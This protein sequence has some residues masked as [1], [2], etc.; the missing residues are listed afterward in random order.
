MTSL[1]KAGQTLPGIVPAWLRTLE[2]T[3]SSEKCSGNKATWRGE[4]YLHGEIQHFIAADDVV[5]RGLKNLVSNT[6]VLIGSQKL[7]VSS[8]VTRVAQLT[9]NQGALTLTGLTLMNPGVPLTV[10]ECLFGGAALTEEMIKHVEQLVALIASLKTPMREFLIDLFSNSEIT[11]SFVSCPASHKH[12]HA[13][14]GGLLIHSVDCA[15]MVKQL[16]MMRM[17]PKEAEV[18]IVAAL[19]HDIGKARTHEATRS[20]NVMGQFVSHESAGLELLAPY[21][22]DLDAHWETG[23]NLLRHMLGWGRLGHKFPDFPGTLLVKMCDQ[24]DTSLDL[25]HQSFE[26]KPSWYGYAYS[27]GTSGQ[28]F[29]RISS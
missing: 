20:Q 3:A 23:A 6:P 4:L 16:A 12:H 2:Y 29:L 11:E 24:F 10:G 22:K 14:P 27:D 25:R 9:K 18:T 26:G 15:L 21:L 17:E 28:R 5:D 1:D 13:K 8:D 7:A 19:L